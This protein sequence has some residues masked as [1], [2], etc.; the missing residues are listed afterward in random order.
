[1]EERIKKL[2]SLVRKERIMI[3]KM[4]EADEKDNALLFNEL[5]E[6][7]KE[8]SMKTDEL[9]QQMID[10]DMYDESIDYLSV[11]IDKKVDQQE[12][13]TD[14]VSLLGLLNIY[15]SNEE[16][17][18][19]VNSDSD[20]FSNEFIM[21]IYEIYLWYMKNNNYEKEFITSIREDIVSKLVN[22]RSMRC[23]FAGNYEDAAILADPLNDFN[24]RDRLGT[25]YAS[26]MMG[27]ISLSNKFEVYD[28]IFDP[29]SFES[30][31]K[32]LEIEFA[33]I[34]TILL[35]RGFLIPPNTM[36]YS[37]FTEQVI[38]NASELVD[39]YNKRIK[40]EQTKILI[41]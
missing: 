33:A 36:D 14:Y 39:K 2:L 17:Q 15:H 26:L 8:C 19:M 34:S 9:L 37:D 30:R 13:V 31:K 20:V 35:R 40:N 24:D 7:Y 25:V 10:D 29:T 4:V 16:S 11:I 12:N 23:Y 1:M 38:A 22:S 3:T 27:Q 6:P 21:Q 18:S 41:K 32:L 5:Q 28:G